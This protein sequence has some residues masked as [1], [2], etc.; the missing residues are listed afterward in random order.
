[1]LEVAELEALPEFEP[2]SRQLAA[3][4]GLERYLVAVGEDV[5]RLTATARV[6]AAMLRQRPVVLGLT[7]LAGIAPFAAFEFLISICLG[8]AD[9]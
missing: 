1:M 8:R 3:F 9:S 7:A 4:E 6:R 2:A 5:A